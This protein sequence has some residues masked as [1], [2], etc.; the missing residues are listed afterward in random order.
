MA[1]VGFIYLGMS[2]SHVRQKVLSGSHIL[3]PCG[4]WLD[5]IFCNKT[6]QACVTCQLYFHVEH[7]TSWYGLRWVGL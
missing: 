2:D 1:E 6:P 5:S 7:L 4:G 3:Q